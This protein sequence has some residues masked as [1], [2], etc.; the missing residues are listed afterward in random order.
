MYKM[1][2]NVVV[3]LGVNTNAS[4]TIDVFG[5]TAPV[6]TNKVIAAVKVPSAIF[7]ASSA[8]S[9]IEFQ[10]Q[11]NDIAGRLET[12]WTA[13]PT[14]TGVATRK[15]LT[16][17]KLQ[18]ALVGALDASAAEPF[19][20]SAKYTDA[21]HKN[22][23]SFGD[24]ALGS[25]AHYL[26]GHVDATAAIDNDTTFISKMNGVGLTDAKLGEALTDLIFSLDAAKCTAIAKQV[27]GQDA[28]RAFGVDNDNT[29]PDG[30]Q[31]LAFKA[32]DKIYVS[33]T[34]TAPTVTVLGN[35]SAQ[36]SEPSSALFANNIKYMIEMTIE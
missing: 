7:Y 30:W 31:K 21:G 8:S 22:Y 3:D 5:Q 14:G 13:D 16:A 15:A 36:Q 23:A 1:S 27:I 20:I 6:I 35:N 17:Q 12:T 26:F 2:V 9:L 33:V 4:G 11:D 10:G 24:L 32:G 18:A 34:L 28:S 29:T 25:Y 19:N